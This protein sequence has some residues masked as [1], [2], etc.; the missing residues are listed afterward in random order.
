[1]DGIDTCNSAEK[2]SRKSGFQKGNPGKPKG[3]RN[4]ATQLV[5]K[6]LS[7]DIKKVVEVVKAAALNNDLVACKLILDRLAP[8][9]RG[10]LVNFDLPAITSA[11]DAELAISAILAACAAGRLTVDESDKLAAVVTRKAEATHMRLV[12]ERLRRLE[13]AQ[14]QQIASY[15]KVA[16]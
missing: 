6:L 14:P 4:R 3:T 12:E 13:Q 8:P 2:A 9:P 7:K 15:R 5:E 10:R 11:A 16:S 1:M